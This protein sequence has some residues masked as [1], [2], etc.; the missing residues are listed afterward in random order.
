MRFTLI[1]RPTMIFVAVKTY[2]AA[3]FIP[4]VVGVSECGRYTTCARIED[5]N[6]AADVTLAA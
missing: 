4:S 6:L 5:V 2:K 3:G 1:S